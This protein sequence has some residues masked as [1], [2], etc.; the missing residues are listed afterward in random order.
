MPKVALEVAE[1][2]AD[3]GAD[4][5]RLWFF[6]EDEVEVVFA[7]F[8]TVGAGLW[9]FVRKGAVE[10]VDDVFAFF[11]SFVEEFEVGGIGD[12]SGGAGGIDEEFAVVRS[13]SR[14]RF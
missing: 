3:G 11:A 9:G 7:G 2:F 8:L 12:V 1:L 13:R 14:R 4:F 10:D 5:V 6:V